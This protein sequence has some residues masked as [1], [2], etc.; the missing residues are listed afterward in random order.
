MNLYLKAIIYSTPTCP[1]C[2][3]AKE[4]FKAKGVVYE[5]FD[6]AADEVKRQEMIKK[7]GG[8]AVPVIEI[9][10]TIMVGFNQAKIDA[11]L[12]GGE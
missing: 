2:K 5:D 7:S 8:L 6:V 12:A 3:K 1:Y 4:Y 10:G 11:A 9:N